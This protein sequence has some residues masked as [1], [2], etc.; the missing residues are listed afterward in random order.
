MKKQ[1]NKN[2]LRKIWLKK[3]KLE[4]GSGVLSV[5]VRPKTLGEGQR[6]FTD[7]TS[8]DHVHLNIAQGQLLGVAVKNGGKTAKDT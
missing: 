2:T 4:N 6:H 7:V 5:S 1:P 3:I 8:T